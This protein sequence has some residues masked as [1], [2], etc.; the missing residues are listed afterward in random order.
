MQ[1]LSK[2]DLREADP[3][4]AEQELALSKL[5]KLADEVDP[6]CRQAPMIWDGENAGDSLLAKQNCLGLNEHGKRV[7]PAC[8]I[9]EQCLETALI[10]QTK[11]GVWG[12]VSAHDRKRMLYSSG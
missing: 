11:F 5:R 3:L 6:V 2:I 8:P 7:R 9:I 10:L 12:G 1:E 4:S